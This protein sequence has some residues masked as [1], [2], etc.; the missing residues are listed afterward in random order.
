MTRRL[1]PA[2]APGSRGQPCSEIV[3]SAHKEKNQRDGRSLVN[4]AT[5]LMGA[6][7]DQADPH[8]SQRNLDESNFDFT[9]DHYA[10]RDTNVGRYPYAAVTDR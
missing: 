8:P 10:Y 4:Y 6:F 1:E 5:P 9:H 3:P 7:G 2:S